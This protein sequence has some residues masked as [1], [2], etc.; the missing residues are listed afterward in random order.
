MTP[1]FSPPSEEES[2][3]LSPALLATALLAPEWLAPREDDRR[4][5][6]GADAPARDEGRARLI[7]LG[8]GLGGGGSRHT[9]PLQ[10]YVSTALRGRCP[11]NNVVT[12]ATDDFTTRLSMQDMGPVALLVDYV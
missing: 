4:R 5:H 3:G 1:I 2:A 10:F 7:V 11:S 6:G 8:K 12:N 9:A